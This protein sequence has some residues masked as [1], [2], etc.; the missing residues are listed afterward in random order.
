M[1]KKVLYVA[2]VLKHINAFHIPYLHYFKE[3]GW[4]THVL[5]SGDDNVKYTDKIFRYDIERQPLRGSNLIQYQKLKKL[6][7][8]E[9]YDLIVCN[10]PV[11]GVL[12][13]LAARKV[14]AK[15]VYIAHGFHF[16]KG[17][18]VKDWLLYYPIEKL[19]SRW[20]DV[21]VTINKDDYELAKN[22]MKAKQV[23][24]VA[25]IG[26][27]VDKFSNIIINK[28]SKRNELGVPL[29][30]TL[31]V[32]V[33]EL[34]TNKNHEVIIR[35]MS[36][37]ENTNYIICGEGELREYILRIA[38]EYGLEERIHIIGYRKDIAEIYKCGDICCF[39]SKREGLGL[40][41]LEGMASGLPLIASD[42]RGIRDY[43]EN[44]VT[45]YLCHPTDV[46]CYAE[47]I[48]KL[49]TNKKLAI[50]FGENNKKISQNYSLKKSM[51]TM[52]KIFNSLILE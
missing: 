25:G 36:H 52:K 11:G 40:A 31:L 26:F 41:A 45:G 43:A 24:Y 14:C 16:F 4:E 38:K 28:D 48:I 8:K 15:V 51:E 34:N 42:I 39:P 44:D 9:Q 17:G 3:N 1:N 50:E 32:S 2:T 10:T 29:D 46:A 49:I 12:A 5:G 37:I 47:K 35:A 33:G 27:D 22:K 30:A 7:I 18:S 19:C 20:T 13:R 23:E 21:L 6:L